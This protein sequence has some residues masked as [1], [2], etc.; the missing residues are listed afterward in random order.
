MRTLTNKILNLAQPS[1]Q[2]PFRAFPVSTANLTQVVD[3]S[4]SN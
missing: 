2:S 3:K 1:L 4:A